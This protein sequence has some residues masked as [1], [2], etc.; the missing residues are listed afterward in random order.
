MSEPRPIRHEEIRLGDRIRVERY[1]DDFA[2]EGVVATLDSSGQHT[3]TKEGW[4]L[5]M[6]DAKER[7]FLLSRPP[8]LVEF[9][10]AR[11]AETERIAKE[12]LE[13]ENMRPYGD[14]TLPPV[15]PEQVPDEMRGYLGG[16]WG[17]HAAHWDMSRALRMV[18]SSRAL[19]AAVTTGSMGSS[20]SSSDGLTPWSRRILGHL[21]SIYSDHPEF[22]QEWVP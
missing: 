2:V 12:A 3:E 18:E 10:H 5:T 6:S 1:G 13:P 9:L 21:A 8:A 20:H 17:E 15:S 7:V 14:K 4:V 11:L 19:I 22:R 16:T